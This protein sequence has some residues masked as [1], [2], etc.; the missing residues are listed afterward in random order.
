MLNTIQQ[1]SKSEIRQL[2]RNKRI[3][4]S[5]S[6]KISAGIN[7]AK[8]LN[9]HQL[10]NAQ[11]IACFLSFDGEISTQ[12]TINS[13]FKQQ[14]QC[15]L[16][17]LKPFKPIR[18]WFMP[19]QQDSL[20]SNNRYAIPEVD[21][22]VNYAQAVSKIDVILL[23]LVAFDQQGRRLGMGGGFYDATLAHLKNSRHRPKLIGLAYEA[24][25]INDLPSDPWDMPLDGVCTNERYY[26]FNED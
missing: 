18:L 17:K 19:Y 1:L 20:M 12:E 26:S 2:I 4:L 22:A 15:Y 24:Q 14:K 8:Q 5:Q 6:V 10:L 25:L 21:L 9:S 23:P 7:L 13:L 11:H 3:N 16:P